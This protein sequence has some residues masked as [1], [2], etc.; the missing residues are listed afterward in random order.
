[1][2]K[3]EINKKIKKE[4]LLNTAFDLFTTKGINK[5]SIS[6][7]VTNAGVAKGTFYLYFSD[8]YDIRNKLISHK[9]TQL[10]LK[11]SHNMLKKGIVSFED[12]IIFIS[13]FIIDEFTNNK[14]LLN[15]ISKN[16]SWGIF[17]AVLSSPNDEEDLNFYTVYED[18][19][20]QS[21]KKFKNPELMIFMI[22]ELV[23]STC[24]SPILYSEPVSIDKMKPEIFDLIRYIIKSQEINEIDAPLY[25]RAW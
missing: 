6:E 1:M 19:L 8:K 7:I 16:L 17:K 25:S 24:Y 18:M 23:S 11:A 20:K 4:S 13:D 9:A 12:K 3:L 10:F 15:F 14:A 22:I 21:G 5:T 2:G